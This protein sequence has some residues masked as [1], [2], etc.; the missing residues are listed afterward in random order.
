MGEED[1]ES[2][3]PLARSAVICMIQQ[4]RAFMGISRVLRLWF[5]P[6]ETLV[7]ASLPLF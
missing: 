7:L 2:I 5:C 6:A 4:V 3:R 1:K